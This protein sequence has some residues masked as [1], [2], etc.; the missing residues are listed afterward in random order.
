MSNESA[1]LAVVEFE[2]AKSSEDAMVTMVRQK[3]LHTLSIYPKLSHSMLQIGLGTSFPS[4]L[5]RPVLDQLISEG[6]VISVQH[7]ET[8]PV[9][10]REQIYT[11]LGLPL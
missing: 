2:A 4:S 10:N 1:S 8:N 3:I 6:Q 7:K 11:L 9:T 5:W